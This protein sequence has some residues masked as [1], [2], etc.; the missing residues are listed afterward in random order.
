MKLFTITPPHFKTIC[1]LTV[2]LSCCLHD[3]TAQNY[4]PSNSLPAPSGISGFGP[5]FNLIGRVLN[6]APFV[7]PDPFNGFDDVNVSVVHNLPS[8]PFYEQCY[9]L[10]Q[11]KTYPQ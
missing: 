8:S 2:L 6:F 9:G 10:Q 4:D 1:F 11:H 5:P 3:V 7:L